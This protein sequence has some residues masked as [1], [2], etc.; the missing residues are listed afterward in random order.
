[1]MFSE[2][3]FTKIDERS[4]D[5][6]IPNDASL[7][8]PHTHTHTHIHMHKFF[9]TAHLTQIQKVQLTHL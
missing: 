9:N 3:R 6:S 4:N 8:P 2:H 1:M 7:C 5:I